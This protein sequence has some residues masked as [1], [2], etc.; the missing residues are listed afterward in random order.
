MTSRAEQ[1]AEAVTSIHQRWPYEARVGLILG[2]G[3]GHLADQVEHEAVIAYDDIPHFPRST[4]LSH[5]GQLICGRLAGVPVLTME[6]RSH[7]YE[8][9]SADEVTFPVRVMRAMGAELLIVSN[10]SGGLN[11]LYASG[12]VMVVADHINLMFRCPAVADS[13]EQRPNERSGRYGAALYDPALVERSLEI[14]RRENFV[15][16]RGVYVAV[17]GPNYETRAEYRF[18]RRIG[19]D[20]VGMSTVP[21]VLV[22][23][24]LGMRV[25]ALS[26]VTNVARP[27]APRTVKAAEVVSVAEHAEPNLRKIVLGIVHS[28]T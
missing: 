13:D 16:H 22:A 6:G 27:D 24:Q 2:T 3:L 23:A 9:Y 14:A 26:T 15:A 28:V 25:L 12:D 20:V 10:A 17:T 18:L 19:G 7:L 11:P 4:A 8:G 21:E 1:V 5:K